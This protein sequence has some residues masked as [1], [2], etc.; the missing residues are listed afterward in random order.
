[1]LQQEQGLVVPEER[2]RAAK[3][4]EEYV[5]SIR[6]N[7]A[8][9]EDNL[10]KT[11]VPEELAARYRALVARANGPKKLLVIGEDWCPDVYRG[12]PVAKRIADAA[13]IELRVVERD[14]H[15]DLMEPFKKDGE[16]LSIPVYVFL[17]TDNCV[18]LHW[19]ERPALANDQMREAMSP[20]F[21][22]SGTRRLT[23][24]LGRAPTEE[25]K[26]TARDEA[27][28]RYDQFQQSSPYWAAWRDAAVSEVLELLEK[29][30]HTPAS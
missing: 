6:V 7:Q 9:F 15:L 10:A 4:Y 8:K 22:P 14:Q 13:G 11:S 3:T 30:L 21:G 20:V 1:M 16:H 27:Q 26:N 5:G 17:T 25:E 12:L 29:A 24:K 23:E 18:I 2:F 19:V 28:Q